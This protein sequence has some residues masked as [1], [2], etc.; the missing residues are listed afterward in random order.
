MPWYLYRGSSQGDVY[1]ASY[2]G[3]TGRQ[4]LGPEENIFSSW[5]LPLPTASCSIAGKIFQHVTF[6]TSPKALFHDK[7]RTLR[8]GGQAGMSDLAVCRRQ[9][10]LTRSARPRQGGSE[11]PLS[12][13]GCWHSGVL[14]GLSS[15]WTTRYTS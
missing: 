6:I 1:H 3:S 11:H 13:H 14:R 5:E 7:S 9:A 10:L 8:R 15:V 2:R 12:L 4:F